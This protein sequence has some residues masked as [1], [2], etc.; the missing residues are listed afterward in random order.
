MVKWPTPSL[1]A[2]PAPLRFNDLM[3]IKVTERKRGVGPSMRG[4]FYSYPQGDVTIVKAWPP[5]RGKPRTRNQEI[6]QRLFT[7]A[8]AAMKRMAPEII[9][10]HR[11][12]S[13]GTPMLPRDA[14]MACLYGRGPSLPMQDGTV[15][16]SMATRVDMSEVMDNLE[17]R[18]GSILFRGDDGYWKGLLVG[19]A[20]Q[21]LSVTGPTELSWVNQMGV[22]FP[23]NSIAYWTGDEWVPL[24]IGTAG[25][26]LGVKNDGSGYE[27]QD[28]A[29]I[30]GSLC[31]L[32]GASTTLSAG[33]TNMKGVKFR[34]F[35]AMYMKE[36]LVHHQ[37]QASDQI[38]ARLVQF[39]GTTTVTAV[40]V[41]IPLPLTQDNTDRREVYTLPT[42]VH[43]QAGVEYGLCLM[44]I[45]QGNTYATR[46]FSGSPWVITA[47]MRQS[48]IFIRA[49]NNDLDV[50]DTIENGDTNTYNF[51]IAV[52]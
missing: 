16:R 27:W 46:V 18:P 15:I 6:A 39:N 52:S 1:S 42:P 28:P 17:W 32:M 22:G 49:A 51:G 10:Y 48:V 25:Q 4:L 37:F 43:L 40:D 26:L 50:G 19:S 34:L 35:K 29:T 33:A 24:E 7:E 13:K 44:T 14:L 30:A 45:N 47:P 38:V 5:K 36:I 20:G 21:I 31:Y 11:E 41:D 12:N 2:A 3:Q 9:D 8:C 23:E